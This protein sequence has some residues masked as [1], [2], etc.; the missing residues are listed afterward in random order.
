MFILINDMY[1]GFGKYT[2]YA[3][4]LKEVV[5][6]ENWHSSWLYGWNRCLYCHGC[7]PKETMFGQEEQDLT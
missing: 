2:C 3:F 6:E 7:G 1:N 4:V 5:G